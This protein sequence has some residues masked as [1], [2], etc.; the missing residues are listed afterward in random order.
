MRIRRTILAAVAAGAVL[1]V[2][3]RAFAFAYTEH[4]WYAALGAGSLWTERLAD[5][6]ILHA[7]AFIV[8][9]AFALANFSA[10]RHSILSLVLPRRLANVEFA[11]AVPPRRLDWAAVA[12]A[13]LVGLAA[14]AAVPQWTALAMVRA[15]P[16]FR[17][18]DP[19]HLV[20]LGFYTSWLPF[21][22]QLHRWAW[23]VVLVTTLAVIALYALTPGLRWESGMVRMTTYVRRHLSTLAAV[24]LLM[25]AWRARLAS[26]TL[27]FDGSGPGGAFTAVDHRWLLPANVILSIGTIA[28]AAL[29]LW[30]AWSRQIV[31]S[32]AALTGVLLLWLGVRQ[33]LP[34]VMRS[35]APDTRA[36]A[37][38]DA[39]YAATREAFTRRAFDL[40][41]G[42]L[43][44]ERD[45]PGSVIARSPH[46]LRLTAMA[47]ITPGARGYLVVGNDLGA[48]A[49]ALDGTPSRIAH[50]WAEQDS[51]L[52]SGE[53]PPQPAILRIRDVGQRVQRLAPVF[54][55]GS[56]P[57][58]VFRADTL[59][60]VTDLYSAS[61][62][63][64]LSRRF[65]VAGERRGY[66]RHAATA[67]THG[68]TGA[69]TILMTP[70]PD[71]IARAWQARF[72]EVYRRQTSASAWIE[73]LELQPNLPVPAPGAS[74]SVF[75]ARVRQLYLR[76]RG[77]L[78]SSDLAGFGVAFDSLGLLLRSADT[79][80][81]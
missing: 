6:V 79:T 70:S 50:A 62:T 11:E 4:A 13:L 69:V 68:T 44:A 45:H 28:A 66:F 61:I 58:A 15:R 57:A 67:Y 20:D 12:L 10:V 77:A 40:S 8:A 60:W 71:P 21:E 74:D 7:S 35:P 81:R 65:I 24:I 43:P 80:A 59:F 38:S 37:V 23:I 14:A 30:S 75:R 1:L 5:T 78:S 76:M 17:E 26:H 19:Y 72:P 52:L 47:H 48:A 32:F 27:L 51:R 64:P 34:L 31:L 53:L 25:L 33:L 3:G 18:T 46:V 16:Q 49:P 29:F 2:L 22:M 63:Y 73:E 39:P 42:S 36:A 55:Q 41:D 56:R 54:A 9:G